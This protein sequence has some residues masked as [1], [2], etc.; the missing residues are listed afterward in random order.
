MGNQIFLMLQGMVFST[1]HTVMAI[2][3]KVLVYRTTLEAGSSR[4]ILS[5][6][7]FHYKF[8]LFHHSIPHSDPHSTPL[9]SIHSNNAVSIVD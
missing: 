4:F 9:F 2:I 7:G 5:L 1:Y 3:T 8:S 6:D